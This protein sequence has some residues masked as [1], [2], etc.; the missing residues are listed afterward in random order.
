M[1]DL[2]LIYGPPWNQPAKLSKH[3]FAKFW[4]KK[5]K[6]LYIEAPINIGSFFTRREEAFELF[7]RFR[8]GPEKVSNNIWISTF[9]YLLPFRGSKY[10]FGASLINSINQKFI[11][12]YLIK[13][14]KQL[15][16][17]NPT[18]IVGSAHILP[19][20]N[21]LNYS[22]LIYHCSDDYTIIPTFP[23]SFTEIEKKLIKKCDLVVTTA[24]ELMK[25]KS[26]FNQNTISIPNGANVKHFSTTQNP[27]TIISEEMHRF[28]KPIIGYIGS[29]FQW[30]DLEWIDFA[31]KQLPQYE[32]IFIG[33]IQINISHLKMKKNIHFLGP[34]PY[35]DLPRYIK[36]FDVA[37]I[38][39]VID[40]V[41]LKA[42]P[43]K[44]YEYLSSGIPIV[45]TELPDLLPF[46]DDVYLVKNKEDY[47]HCIKAS[48]N[49][50]SISL[51][52]ARMEIAKKYSWEYRFQT[53]NHH[54][55]KI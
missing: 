10:F 33:P 28:K 35:E 37:V 54:I 13:Q 7:K 12:K 53:L 48:I 29:V 41:T 22:R 46:K 17:N 2:V 36:A 9:I 31:A 26:R 1:N 20:L 51:M 23:E 18:I 42:S 44:F 14:M 55:E 16:I 30:L 34:K 45:S 49:N 27:K 19:I 3:H 50:D 39:F 4:S 5:A 15:G 52:N 24:D 6:V 8:K 38:P 11:K 25:D 40:G 21:D 47:I 43:I 32:F